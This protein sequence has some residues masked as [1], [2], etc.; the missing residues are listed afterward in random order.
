MIET[1]RFATVAFFMSAASLTACSAEVPTEPET[2]DGAEAPVAPQA[3]SNEESDTSPT[4][5]RVAVDVVGLTPRVLRKI[6]GMPASHEP[7]DVPVF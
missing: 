3:E 4:S 1:M 7:I 2:S 5:P 6:S